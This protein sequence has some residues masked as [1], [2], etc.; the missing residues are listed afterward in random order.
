MTLLAKFLRRISMSE[1][2]KMSIF[3][4]KSKS[5]I[6]GIRKFSN[7]E[8]YLNMCDRVFI[9]TDLLE[10]CLTHYFQSCTLDRLIWKHLYDVTSNK[11]HKKIYKHLSMSDTCRLFYQLRCLSYAD[12]NRLAGK[13][14]CSHFQ[15][16]KIAVE[17]KLREKGI[18]FFKISRGM[19]S[20]SE[21]K[22]F[23]CFDD[24]KDLKTHCFFMVIYNRNKDKNTIT[25]QIDDGLS[26][27]D[28]LFF[29]DSLIPDF[30]D[31][32]DNVI[33]VSEYIILCYYLSMNHVLHDGY[34]QHLF[35]T[36][37]TLDKNKLNCNYVG[38]RD[39]EYLLENNQSSAENYVRFDEYIKSLDD[40]LEVSLSQK[41]VF[42]ILSDLVLL[43]ALIMY[44]CFEADEYGI[45]F[46]IVHHLHMN[47]D[48][49]TQEDLR[50]TPSGRKFE[51]RHF[52]QF[53]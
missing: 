41:H 12:D 27:A 20:E 30:L 17:N 4:E 35:F 13:N 38:L 31:S 34:L 19:F 28:P 33:S 49:L 8:A 32:I 53:M 37:G 22:E 10:E 45:Q 2:E 44:K 1:A 23:E 15:D 26:I 3:L 43:N 47:T 5:S 24:I 39:M 42:S 51:Y 48:F 36:K 29:F 50:I 40:F 14:G 11:K 6:T 46:T 25:F 21:V 9:F 7:S 16:I 52:G 18:R